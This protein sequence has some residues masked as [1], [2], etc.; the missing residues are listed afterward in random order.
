[1]PL[2]FLKTFAMPN[3]P[4]TLQEAA[5]PL[6]LCRIETSTEPEDLLEVFKSLDV[7]LMSPIGQLAG[8]PDASKRILEAVGNL[9][10]P[11][12]HNESKLR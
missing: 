8:S 6:I 3:A 9:L 7:L 2:P 5:K 10:A 12:S 4:P 11:S 1:M